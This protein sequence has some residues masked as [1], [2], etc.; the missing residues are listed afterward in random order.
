MVVLVADWV[1]PGT[2]GAVSCVPANGLP[3]NIS[4]GKLCRCEG[5]ILWPFL[6]DLSKKQM[7]VLVSI[8]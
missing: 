3:L 1:D 8:L 4:F 7:Y 6:K 5:R 2:H